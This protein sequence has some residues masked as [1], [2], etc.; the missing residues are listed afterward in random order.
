MAAVFPES[1]DKLNRKD[2][3]GSFAILENYIRYMAERTEFA[4]RQTTRAVSG[5][6]VSN[7]EVVILLESINNNLS[8]L[9]S[10]VNLVKG[11]ITDLQNRVDALEGE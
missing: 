1:M 11:Q 2:V 8:A 6:G 5:A 10:E 3:E 9:Y 4:M 7:P